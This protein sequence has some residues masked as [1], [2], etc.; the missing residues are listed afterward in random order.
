[1]T[2]EHERNESIQVVQQGPRMPDDI[3]YKLKWSQHLLSQLDHASKR[4]PRLSNML[5]NNILALI[6]RKSKD[7]ADL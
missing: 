1:M 4:E 2:F 3:T 5:H 6:G 7:A